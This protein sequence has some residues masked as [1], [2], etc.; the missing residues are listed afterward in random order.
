[1]S[2]TVALSALLLLTLAAPV[3]A[4]EADDAARLAALID[5][6]LAAPTP[7]LDFLS[8]L[9]SLGDC[10]IDRAGVEQALAEAD[11]PAASP[12]RQI[13]A[14]TTRI[15]VAGDRLEIRRRDKTT[16]TMPGGAKILLDKK[17]SLRTRS[18]KASDVDG[19][20]G[21]RIRHAD[22][23]YVQLTRLEGVKVGEAGGN[24]YKLYD[25]FMIEEGGVPVVH[26]KAGVAFFKKWARLEFPPVTAAAPTNGASEAAPADS[27]GI[28]GVL[29]AA[30]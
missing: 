21:D 24:L 20:A 6:A 22:G 28:V 12:I 16:I 30:E 9:G 1:M 25:L 7:T 11:P 15:E 10:S 8:R 29:A 3:Q 5:S 27:A 17:V 2:R 19:S 14:A 4:Q 13:L 18:G 26:L 23:D